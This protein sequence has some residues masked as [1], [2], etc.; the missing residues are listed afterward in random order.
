VT[1][2]KEMIMAHS[3]NA[4]RLLNAA[5]TGDLTFDDPVSDMIKFDRF[6]PELR[7][8]I[9]TNNTK[10]SAGAFEK[11]VAWADRHGLGPGRTIAKI[12]EFEKNEIAVFAGQYRGR[13]GSV[14]PH[15]AAGASV[16]R[17]GSL[18]A[19]KHPARLVGR[20]IYRKPWRPRRRR[21]AA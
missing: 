7:F 18:G 17:Y 1:S 20:P 13:Y 5:T 12:N 9:A 6:P 14:L 2:V 10:L 4:V 21:R 11:H 16:Q 8:R 15:I 3:P 19:S